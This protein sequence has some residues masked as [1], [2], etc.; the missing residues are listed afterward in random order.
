LV[1]NQGWIIFGDSGNNLP[2]SQKL[3]TLSDNWAAGP[4]LYENAYDDGNCGVQVNQMLHFKYF[5][6]ISENKYLLL[7][8]FYSETDTNAKTKI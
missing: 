7:H 3:Q 2:T 4:N 6:S 8:M 5:I 1:P